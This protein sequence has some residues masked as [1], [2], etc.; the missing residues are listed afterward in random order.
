MF[1]KV[2]RETCVQRVFI[3]IFT[4]S[5]FTKILL[6]EILFLQLCIALEIFL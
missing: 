4:E 5:L 1:E 3:F 2:K 6:T